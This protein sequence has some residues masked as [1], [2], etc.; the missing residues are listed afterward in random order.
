[1]QDSTIENMTAED[2][3]AALKPRVNGSWNLHKLL[4]EDMDFFIMLS[5]SA[6]IAG[7]RGQ[8]NY[9]AA[10]TYQDALA[11][12]RTSQHLPAATTDLGMILGVGYVAD[13]SFQKAKGTTTVGANLKN[14]GVLRICEEEFLSILSA[15]IT[16]FGKRD[17]TISPQV[18]TGIS[19]GGMK[20]QHG[21]SV[22]A[23]A[24]WLHDARLSHLKLLDSQTQGRGR[25]ETSSSGPQ[26]AQLLAEATSIAAASAIVCPAITERLA[27]S[28]MVSIDDA[29]P[30]KPVNAH[31]VDSLVAVEPRN[32]IFRE[33]KAD[34]SVFDILS[35]VPLTALSSKIAASSKL[36]RAAVGS[37]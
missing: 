4:P 12:Y 31:G 21:A 29:D 27:K 22:P 7:G 18:I 2:M 33:I 1:M 23:D 37:E 19:T 6:G 8:A 9:S 15:A 20:L 25:R 14:L 30:S 36:V 34:V 5:S 17:S 24:F 26:I 11:H 16:R 32:F 10:N 3:S 28:M 13:H 35:S